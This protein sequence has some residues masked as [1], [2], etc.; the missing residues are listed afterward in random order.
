MKNRLLIATIFL[1]LN[2][3][4]V[5][6]QNYLGYGRQ[7]INKALKA[8]RK[9]LKGP[10]EMRDNGGNYIFYVTSDNKRAVIYHF[11]KMEVTLKNGKTIE[12]EI[13]IKYVS[14]NQCKSFTECP[15]MDAV[16]RSIASRFTET[17]YRTWVDY[18]KKVPQEWVVVQ[19]D[20]YFEVHVEER[21]ELEQK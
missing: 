12:E 9:D 17:G 1:I 6:A 20:D 2:C 16:I 10:V 15:E 19:E 7:Y 8:E 21:K 4:G 14:R 5:M 3:T 11:R 13:C 18:S